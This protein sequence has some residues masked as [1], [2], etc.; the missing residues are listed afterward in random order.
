MSKCRELRIL[1]QQWLW[2]SHWKSFLSQGCPEGKK[3]VPRPHR[4]ADETEVYLIPPAPYFGAPHCCARVW[5]GWRKLLLIFHL[6]ITFF[7]ECLHKNNPHH[8]PGRNA[9]ATQHLQ[10]P[11]EEYKGDQHTEV[12]HTSLTDS[13]RWGH[14]QLHALSWENF[15]T[16]ASKLPKETS[17]SRI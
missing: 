11:Y 2:L 13:H 4:T 10:R 17:A 6:E 5:N 9:R 7:W 8:W 12:P 1:H 15:V 3:L 16:S 14:P